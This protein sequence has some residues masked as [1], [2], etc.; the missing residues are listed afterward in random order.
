VIARE[1]CLRALALFLTT[2]GCATSP[3]GA[4][5][6]LLASTRFTHR[7]QPGWHLRSLSLVPAGDAGREGVVL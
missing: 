6:H 5:E 1:G 4:G 2:L 7:V 3:A